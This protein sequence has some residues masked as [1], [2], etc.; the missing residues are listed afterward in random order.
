MNVLL[1]SQVNGVS[2]FLQIK[3]L[4]WSSTHALLATAAAGVIL[5]SVM[6]PVSTPTSTVI[7]ISSVAVAGQ[8]LTL[9]GF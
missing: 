7:L 5:R 3:G 2:M 6:T 9:R 4:T 1:C 8:V